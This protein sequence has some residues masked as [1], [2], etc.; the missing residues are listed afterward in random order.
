MKE[1][2]IGIGKRIRSKREYMKYTREQLSEIVEISPQFLAD[3]ESGKKG[4]SFSTL[5]KLC[6][7]LGTSCDYIIMG[8]TSQADCSNL[9]ELLHN[10]DESYLPLAEELL[11]TFVKTIAKSK[12]FSN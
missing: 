6:S 11:Q 1:L 10:I 2:N 5:T 8:K 4:M 12:E 9:I 7:A 3:I